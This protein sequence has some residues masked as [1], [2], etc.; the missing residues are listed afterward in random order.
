MLVDVHD[1]KNVLALLNA[2]DEEYN[3]FLASTVY[4]DKVLICEYRYKSTRK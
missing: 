1:P 3:S 2:P 4:N